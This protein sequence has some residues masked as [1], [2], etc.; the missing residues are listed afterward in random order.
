MKKC[1]FAVVAVMALL[2][3]SCEKNVKNIDPSQLD[4]TVNRCW[5]ITFSKFGVSASTYMWC[6]ERECVEALQTSSAFA[7]VNASYS[8]AAASDADACYQLDEDLQR[9]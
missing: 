2:L 6:T 9:E 1:I 5:K 8:V 4:N 3:T 7:G